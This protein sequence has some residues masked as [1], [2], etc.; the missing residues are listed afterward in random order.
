MKRAKIYQL[1]LGLVC[2]GALLVRVEGLYWPKLHPDEPVIGA[3]LGAQRFYIRD[4]V[5]PN[6]FFVLARP[7]VMLEEAR[8]RLQ[9]RFNYFCGAID[10]ERGLKP[11]GIYVGRWCNA[12]AGALL[13]LMAFRLAAGICRSPWAGLVAAG[14]LGFAQYPV[15]HSHY[16]ETDIAALLVMMLALWLWVV[17]RDTGK[18]RWLA[19]AALVSGF[20]AGTKFT[21][22][23][24]APLLI[25]EAVLFARPRRPLA[26]LLPAGGW[27]A[28]G[29]LLFA[30]G[31]AL[32]NPA[33]VLNWSW[34][35]SGLAAEQKRVFAETMLNLGPLGA[36]PAV[37]YLHHLQELRLYARTLGYPWL[38]L[39]AAGL[40]CA[41][42]G[43]ARRHWPVLILFPL[44]FG[45]YWV[46][47]A[48]WVRSQ[49]FL[50]FLPALAALAVLPLQALWR[51]QHYAGRGAAALIA[52]AAIWVNGSHGWR[53]AELFGWKDTRLLARQWLSS[54]LPLASRVAVESYAEAACPELWPA[55]SLRK[56][57]EQGMDF[58]RVRQPDY[59]VRA[60]SITG[61]GLRHPLTGGLY[62]EAQR[63]WQQFSAGSELLGAWAPLSAPGLATFASPRLELYGLRPC[64]PAVALR[65]ELPQPALIVNGDQNTVGRQTFFPIGRELGSRTALLIDQLPQTIAIGGP[66][67]LNTPV[68]LVFN[69]R[70][71][72]AVINVRGF[73]HKQKAAL[74]PYDTAVVALKRSGYSLD[75]PPFEKITLQA[76]PVEDV[77][78]IP[79][80][81]R[82][83]FSVA[84]AARLVLETGRPDRLAE[85]FSEERLEQEL[86]PDLKYIIAVQAG[87]WSMAE[88]NAAAAQARGRQI[89]QGLPAE[90]SAVAV[91]GHSGYFYDQLARLRW[92]RPDE[93]AWISPQEAET[94]GAEEG[95]Y[96][97][98]L[99]PILLARGE[100]ELRGELMLRTPAGAPAAGLPMV[101]KQSAGWSNQVSQLALQPGQ[102]HNF[103]LTLQADREM[104]PCFEFQAPVAAQLYLR[105]LEITWSLAAALK[106]AR[107][108]LAA[109]AAAHKL[110]RLAGPKAAAAPAG[111]RPAEI[112][113]PWLALV[114]FAFDPRAGEV[115]CVF[116]ALRDD[117]PPL[118]ATCWMR[119]HGAWR[120]KQ[121]QSISSGQWLRKGERKAITIRLN[122]ALRALDAGQLGLGVET[123]VEWHAGAIPL[124]EGGQVAP[125]A[126]LID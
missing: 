3:W 71:R 55:L 105:N 87:F 70:E 77:L 97:R 123:D 68:F 104:Q 54:R 60:A 61:R 4:R 45:F 99:L 95:Y 56:I 24:L 29:L 93:L 85:Y 11:D 121:V 74:A 53:V 94:A 26:R 91:N 18:A 65:V 49:E 69:T 73:G 12:L 51:A 89:E 44:I 118:A 42:L 98:L 78:Y 82:I 79:C 23:V 43:A 25:V 114:E 58:L 27:V 30:L 72:P 14:L 5:Y 101:F 119:R 125:F 63:Q 106:A 67:P 31:F 8:L 115:K 37:R 16:A 28:A 88:R 39:I 52:A 66:A 7:V 116:E 108:E 81:A 109:A 48:P 32:A 111:Q 92:Q 46:F 117:T 19:I 100:Y 21:L 110:H 124:A 96:L 86:P 62:P 35:W 83:A 13:G 38:A 102:W 36:R 20:A 50:F 15:E 57:E 22:M 80:F 76:E 126:R 112:F 47:M 90:S 75:Q 113:A 103:Q 9:Q 84:E 33:V 34:F 17:A 6:G 107:N 122:A 1:L 59:L 40:P 64:A 120:R 2:L 10:R 41:C